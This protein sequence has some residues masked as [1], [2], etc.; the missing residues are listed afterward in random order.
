MF[1]RNISFILALNTQLYYRTVG[2][3]SQIGFTEMGKIQIRVILYSSYLYIVW[4]K[5]TQVGIGAS[6]RSVLARHS[7]VK[8]NKLRHIFGK[9]KKCFY[10]DDTYIIM[11]IDTGMIFKREDEKGMRGSGKNF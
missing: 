5:K 6:N 1:I 10:E 4:D 11:K 3:I 9:L 8:Y 7:G 2:V